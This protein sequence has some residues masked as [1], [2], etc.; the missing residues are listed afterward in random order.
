MPIY[1]DQ[2]NYVDHD[3]N[4]TT[5]TINGSH[6][7]Q[8]LEELEV[9]RDR[10]SSTVQTFADGT[11]IFVN[12][13]SKSGEIRLTFAESSPTTDVLQAL[14]DAGSTFKCSVLDANATKLDASGLCKVKKHPNIKRKAD[15][16]DMVQ[17]VL[18][19]VYLKMQGG[20]YALVAA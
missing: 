20:S 17:W 19:S 3:F 1:K 18:V 16:T 4:S 11:G 12:H 8:G 10:E 7:V 15:G 5:V 2:I 13:A 9:E 14:F 6:V